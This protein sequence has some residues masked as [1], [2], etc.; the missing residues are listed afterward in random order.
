MIALRG[1]DCYTTFAAPVFHEY[2]GAVL[3]I[4]KS[5]MMP[6]TMSDVLEIKYHRV[7]SESYALRTMSNSCARPY[8]RGCAFPRLECGKPSV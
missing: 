6:R 8:L 1:S 7:I 2:V 5:L 3:T 4:L